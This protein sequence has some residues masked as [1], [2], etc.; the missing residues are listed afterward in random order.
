MLPANDV[1]QALGFNRLKRA[2]RFG[3]LP[4]NLFVQ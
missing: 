1:I 2:L 4:T 3:R